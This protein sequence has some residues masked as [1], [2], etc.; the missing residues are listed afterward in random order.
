MAGMLLMKTLPSEGLGAAALAACGDNKGFYA[1]IAQQQQQAAGCVVLRKQV[2]A[3]PLNMKTCT[4]I[5][6][7]VVDGDTPASD[8]LQAAALAA[9]SSASAAAAA[10]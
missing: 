8:G 1:H 2:V 10:K 3:L 5:A 9:C 6:G 7:N 4:K